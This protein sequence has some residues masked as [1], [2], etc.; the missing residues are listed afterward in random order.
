MCSKYRHIILF[1]LIAAAL[2][3]LL[4]LPG[5][6]KKEKETPLY[7]IID[8]RIVYNDPSASGDEDVIFAGSPAMEG[9]GYT[10]EESGS[11]DFSAVNEGLAY[12]SDESYNSLSSDSSGKIDL[13]KLKLS[14]ACAAVRDIYRAAD[15]GSSLN[16]TLSSADIASMISAC[17]TAG[18]PAADSRG[19]FN[20]QG[21]GLMH[22]FGQ[23]LSLSNGDISETYFIVYPDGHL[24]GFMLSRESG[25]WH[26]Y[27]ASAAWNDDGT[28]RIYSEGRYAVGEV[29]Y[30]EKGWL[31]Y[32]RDTSDFDENQKA[33]TDSY[34]MVRVLPYDSEMRTL[35]K[36][37]VEP[38]GYFENNLF[39]TDWNEG[40]MGPIDFNSLYAYVFGLYN[41]TDMLSSYNVRNYYKA[42]QGTK[43]YL[44]P[45]D[46]FENNTTVYFN[47]DRAALKNI[48]DYSSQ[49]GGYLF[50]GYNRDYYNVTP[51][52]P[53]PEVVDYSY[54]SDGTITLTVDAVNNWYGTDRAFRH[55]LVVRPTDGVSFR[56]V[57]NTLQQDPNNIIPPMKLS[58]MLN[59]ELTK[60]TF[61]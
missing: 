52:T 42:V 33:N 8:G 37:Y 35:C 56:Y 48:S 57:S 43:L 5:C 30:T 10:A 53:F 44:I 47:I 6:G 61:G 45:E 51:R 40:N 50:L 24:S 36:R 4:M 55:T 39:T 38:V 54:N 1:P 28:E 12:S 60:T 41:G 19:D 9:V 32:S 16:V 29:R 31:I 22:E 13:L 2:F 11:M 15:K 18:Y 58:E 21:Y 20:M 17:G 49:L 25:I 23:T 46:I 14:G 26:L 3:S 27:S 34:V 59:V 7:E